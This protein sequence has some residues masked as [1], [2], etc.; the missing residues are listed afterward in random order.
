MCEDLELKVKHKEG[1]AK[2]LKKLYEYTQD[3][4][5][6]MLIQ[7]LDNMSY[8]SVRNMCIRRGMIYSQALR[9]K[10]IYTNY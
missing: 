10:V 2:T 5:Y 6:M 7:T 8:D 3:V 1:F 4:Y 9:G